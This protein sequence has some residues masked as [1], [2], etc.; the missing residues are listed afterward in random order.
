LKNRV[1]RHTRG[2]DQL[3]LEPEQVASYL[4]GGRSRRAS[5]LLQRVA[6]EVS[7][8][9]VQSLEIRNSLCLQLLL[10]NAKRA[11]DVVHL[12]REAVLNA[13]SDK[14]NDVEV[15]VKVSTTIILEKNGYGIN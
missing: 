1:E 11:R 6:S 4:E 10:A 13:K 14:G 5:N 15:E 7:L 2:E 8:T 9:R 12:Q 3:D